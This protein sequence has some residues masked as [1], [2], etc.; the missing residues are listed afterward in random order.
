VI[1]PK[2]GNSAFNRAPIPQIPG[3]DPAQTGNDA[4]LGALVRRPS[5]QATNCSV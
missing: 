2:L 1:D 4:D 3:L 5:S